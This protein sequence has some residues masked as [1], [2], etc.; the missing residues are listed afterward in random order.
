MNKKN[1][2]LSGVIL[3]LVAKLSFAAAG[4]APIAVWANEAII[5]T[6]SY[7]YKNYLQEQKDIAKYFTSAGWIAYTKALN[8]SKLPESVQKNAYY[9]SAVATHP[10]AIVTLD[11]E[12]WQITMPILVV[13]KNPQYE[14][15][16]SLKVV[17]SVSAVPSGQG[18]RGLA[19]TNLR[20]TV[21]E[22]PCECKAKA[23][24][25]GKSSTPTVKP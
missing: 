21:T 14:Q 25:N 24:V 6:Y 5:A 4:P 20:A 9:V 15:Q 22:P 8:D 17:I 12:N 18:V 3:F 1:Q 7:D 11:P 16:Q 13:Y 2:F 10:A 23:A 19:I